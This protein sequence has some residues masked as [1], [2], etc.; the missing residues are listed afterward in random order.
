[1]HPFLMVLLILILPLPLAYW[2]AIRPWHLRWG[3]TPQETQ[4][5]LPG[6]ELVGGPKILYT[7]AITIQAPAGAVWPWLVQIGYKRAGWYSYDGLER[8]A[9]AADFVDG[10]T[11][12]RRI[13]PELQ[14][15]QVGDTIR[16]VAQ[17]G[18]FFTIAALEPGRVLVL[19]GGDGTDPNPPA[20]ISW[21]FVLEESGGVTRLLVRQR[22][23]YKPGVG[24][25]LMWHFT[26]PLNFLMER[27]MLK[28]IKLRAEQAIVNVGINH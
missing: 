17:P 24:H 22:L 16:I 11:S 19:R 4:R 1:M 7:R 14:Q 5:P 2:W 10:H 13:V 23:D 15:V 28:G 9:Q 21:V 18:P 20:E 27:K 8:L 3:A 6:D 26:E 25:W 12:A